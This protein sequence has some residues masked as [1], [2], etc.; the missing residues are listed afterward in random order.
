MNYGRNNIPPLK[1]HQNHH[2]QQNTQA[3]GH[4][5]TNHH[6][7]TFT[8]LPLMPIAIKYDQ[9]KERIRTKRPQHLLNYCFLMMAVFSLLVLTSRRTIN[10]FIT[11]S[12]SRAQNENENGSVYVRFMFI[13]NIAHSS[14]SMVGCLVQLQCHASI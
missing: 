12:A 3:H 10:I 4:T 14:F 1:Q 6:A 2:H 8:S 9:S 11:M 13:I 7:I 5:Y